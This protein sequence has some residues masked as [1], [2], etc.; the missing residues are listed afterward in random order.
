MAVRLTEKSRV[1]VELPMML[2]LRIADADGQMTAHEMER[3]DELLAT[4]A[5]ARSPLLRRALANAA[6]EK[7]ALWKS[8]ASG[9]MR[10]GTEQVAAALDT[11]LCSLNTE[12][13]ADIERD[14]S[15]FC[16]EL[17]AAS[18]RAAGL[19][20]SDREAKATSDTLLQLIRKP[21]ARAAVREAPHPH[22]PGEQDAMSL[23]RA[24]FNAEMF[25]QRG[26]LSLRCIQVIDETHDVK[27]FRLVAD[28][29]RLFR[30]LPG[31]FITIEAP[32]DGEILRRSY[33][34]SASPSRPHSLSV[35]VKRTAAG[36]VSNWLHQ[37]LKVGD[38]IFADG[39]HGAF[40]FAGNDDPGPYLFISAGSGVSPLIA[41]TRWLVD[42][43]P[44]A[45]VRF[46]HF[47]H[48]PGDLIFE[49]E[50]RLMERNLPGLHTA[51]VVTR[52]VGDEPW[53]GR[54]GRI[55]KELLSELVP[56]LK[57]RSAY[58]CGPVPF[59]ETT[60]A[61]LADLGFEM[62]HCHQEFFGGV[63]KRDAKAAEA[64]A[65]TPAKLIFAAS[66]IEVDCRGSDYILDLAIAK[67]LKVP[68]SCR[69]GHCG[70]CKV[71][72]IAGTV[73]QDRTT[74]LNPDDVKDGLILACQARPIGRVVVDL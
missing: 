36:K 42:T 5:W 65:N 48:S 18:Q 31:Q 59:M 56:D 40:T 27:T 11:V 14:L 44:E 67:G 74:G 30:Y 41:M 20:G 7:A 58:I 3:F 12:E 10:A 13:R 47:A 26:K 62:R 63:P 8:Y 64:Q 16:G 33:S 24:E 51:F 22:A 29:P 69:A 23:L 21:S 38:T 2:F 19:F 9:S 32:I 1:L 53:T 57:S 39:P 43:T 50:L 70:T 25:W 17:N 66:N 37:N 4:R 49:N 45:D 35:T 6:A 34:I 61:I 72:L 28:P 55:S 54:S 71:T 68:Y 46:L 60:T 52:T 73:E 15:Y